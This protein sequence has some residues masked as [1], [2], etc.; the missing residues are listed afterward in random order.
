[1]EKSALKHNG[2]PVFK[3][4][5]FSYLHND[6]N[7]FGCGVVLNDCIKARGFWTGPD[8]FQHITFKEL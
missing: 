6:S 8:K 4:I 2:A 3:P 5:E 1:M 7:G